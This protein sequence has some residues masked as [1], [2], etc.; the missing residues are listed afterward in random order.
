MVSPTST[1]N[2]TCRVVLIMR[3]LCW[4]VIQ[5][6][7]RTNEGVHV[8]ERVHTCSHTEEDVDLRTYTYHEYV[9]ARVMVAYLDPVSLMPMP[10]SA[11]TLVRP[12]LSSVLASGFWFG[13]C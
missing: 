12:F 13:T 5:T 4:T 1:K 10:D 8:H 11:G 3:F 6:Q 2:C 7:P 9:I